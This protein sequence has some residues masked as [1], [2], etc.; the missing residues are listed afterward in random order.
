MSCSTVLSFRL[1]D[2]DGGELFQSDQDFHGFG[3]FA[4]AGIG[5]DGADMRHQP[6]QS[7]GF[8][9]LQRHAQRRARDPELLAEQ[10]FRQPF[11]GLPAV[12]HDVAPKMR[13]DLIVHRR[14][15]HHGGRCRRIRTILLC[16]SHSGI[17]LPDRQDRLT[18]P[19]PA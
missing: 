10:W 8:Q 5:H 11:A 6:D 14:E 16:S 12:F 19:V 1:R 17:K 15:P 4:G 9:R 2:A 3:D 13:Q 7:L 18:C